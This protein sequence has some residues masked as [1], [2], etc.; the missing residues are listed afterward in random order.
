MEYLKEQAGKQ[1]DPAVVHTFLDSA[2]R[3]KVTQPLIK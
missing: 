2:I 3:R 1:F